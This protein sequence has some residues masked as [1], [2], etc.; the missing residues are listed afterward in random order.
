MEA[1]GINVKIILVQVANFAIL[2][3]IL[4]RFLYQPIL[5]MLEKR[6]KDA[7]DTL[8]L[9]STLEKNLAQAEEDKQK[10]IKSGKSEADQIIEDARQKGQRLT[11]QIE[12]AAKEKAENMLAKAKEEAENTEV[13]LRNQLKSEVAHVAIEVAEQ[14]LQSDLDE[15]NRQSITKEAVRRFVGGSK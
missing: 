7:E 5:K 13:E 1:L 10:I 12:E 6:Q 3:L 11:V 14:V 4:K 2:L 15:Q 8:V 9:K